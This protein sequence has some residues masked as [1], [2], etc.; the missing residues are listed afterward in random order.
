MKKII[1]AHGHSS[2]EVL[3]T[4]VPLVL[5]SE[6]KNEW[7]FKF[8]DY[9]LSNIFKE[10]G[11][12]L[13]LVRKYHNYEGGEQ[14]VI[15]EM[16]KLKKNFKKIIY[17]DDSASPS[18]VFFCI[19]PYVDQY[20]KRAIFLDLNLYKKNFY[21]NRLYSDYY[22]KNYGIIN[23][24]EKIT[25]LVFNFNV[26]FSKLK[27]AWNV[28]VGIYSLN[29][30][31][32]LD[33]NYSIMRRI[34]SVSTL[35]P[36]FYFIR[37]FIKKNIKRMKN[38]LEKK[39][40]FNKKLHKLSARF[41]YH[42]YPN[43]IGFQR[44]LFLKKIE[45]KQNFLTGYLSRVDFTKETF[46]TFGVVSPYGWGEIC[47]RDFEAC[48]GGS[49]LIKPDMSHLSTWPNIY[50]KDM[51]HSLSWDFSDLENIENIFDDVEN[52]KNAVNKSR[53]EYLNSLELSVSRCIKMIENV[54]K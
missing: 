3:H 29:E 51:Y 38:E 28:G 7:D 1:V 25:D 54:L 19:F 22:H 41:S 50:K 15:N 34:V 26:D 53:L 11:D 12:L 40:S 2:I 35:F 52:C 42:N 36:G 16:S 49:Y 4:L 31:S 23:Q 37:K 47:Y 8:V 27:I 45:K 43:T 6:E 39:I 9:K 13:I 44:K 24:N 14:S 5:T 21:G 10:S 48:L 30:K 33:K 46:E 17:F 20:W 32:F 18:I